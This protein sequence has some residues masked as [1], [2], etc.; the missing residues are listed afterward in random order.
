MG[1][2]ADDAINDG[3]DMMLLEED[4]PFFFDNSGPEYR[5]GGRSKK[6][7]PENVQLH[8]VIV[9]FETAKA[10]LITYKDAKGIARDEWFPK[11]KVTLDEDKKVALVPLWMMKNKAKEQGEKD[12]I[13]NEGAIILVYCDVCQERMD[14]RT[15]K[16]LNIEEDIQGADVLTFRC[17]KCRTEQKSR[18]YAR[19]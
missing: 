12:T 19:R 7:P 11:S 5:G 6:P 8:Y 14:E 18:R 2:H 13:A 4:D 10:Y 1:D 3:I 17:P 9:K 16:T 15:V